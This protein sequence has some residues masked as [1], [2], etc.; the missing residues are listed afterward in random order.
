MTIIIMAAPNTPPKCWRWRGEALAAG[1]FA[2]AAQAYG[3]VL[4]D[5]PGHPASGGGPGAR[6]SGGA[7]KSSRRKDDPADGA[8]RCGASDEAI[9][10]VEAELKLKERARARR[11]KRRHRRAA[12]QGRGR[13]QGSPGAL[14]PGA[15]A[16]RGRR[17]RRRHRAAAG[18]RQPRPQMERGSGAQA[19]GD[20][21]RRAGLHRSAHRRRPAQAVGDPV[22]LMPRHYHAWSDLPHSLP[23]FP[24]TGAV[25]LPRGQLPLNVFE[26]RY[27]EMVD[28]ALQGDRLIG[29]IQPTESEETVLRPKLSA[30]GCA[31]KIVAFQE[32]QDNRY[33]ITLA[34]IC[35][36]RLT[37][38]MES[39]TA[40]RAG[41]CDFAPFAGDLVAAAGRGFPARA[42]AGGAEGL[43]LQPRHEGGLE[44]R[45]DRAGRGAGQ[46]AGDDVPLRSGRETGAAGSARLPGPRLDPDG[47]AG[48]GRRRRPTTVDWHA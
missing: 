26:P 7:A 12:R 38:E 13:S 14:R 39:T 28:Y 16:G 44:Q 47:A 43:S 37:G 45:A 46:C 6:L 18:A 1:D 33:L 35:R 48:N 27:L 29:M 41:T 36:F 23:L 9:R 25:L 22:L 5:E 31:G 34:G 2:M 32:T 10:A 20:A 40:W 19:A 24:L 42:A 4:Q 21:V 11:R 17:P 30:V 15:G 3:H 8:P